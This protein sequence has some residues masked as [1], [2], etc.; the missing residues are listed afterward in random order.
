MD[1]VVSMVIHTGINGKG[2][3]TQNQLTAIQTEILRNGH[4]YTPAF[5]NHA[6]GPP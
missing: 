5:I 2:S 4:Y 1:L 6:K 3:M